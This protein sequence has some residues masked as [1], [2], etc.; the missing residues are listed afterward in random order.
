MR[1]Q[2]F[3]GIFIFFICIASNSR[4]DD[5]PGWRGPNRNGISEESDWDPLALG[6]VDAVLWRTEIGMGHS[7]VVVVG[8]HCYAMGNIPIQGVLHDAIA[9]LDVDTGM[10]IWRYTYPCSDIQY[11]GPRATPQT[12]PGDTLRQRQSHSSCSPPPAR[13][14]PTSR[15][16][17][18]G[19]ATA[20]QTRGPPGAPPA[21]GTQGPGRIHWLPETSRD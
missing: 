21:S 14:A 16:Q 10:E 1:K 2:L 4:A 3:F 5:W 7:S 12:N 20:H 8:D 15:P 11:P 19:L 6:D 18:R 17:P 9:C 13:R